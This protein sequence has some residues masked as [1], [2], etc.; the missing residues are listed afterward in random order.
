MPKTKVIKVTPSSPEPNR[1]REAAEVIRSGGLVAFP[2]ETVYGL[3][4]N[5]LL[6]RAVRR[7]FEVKRR[8][9]DN[10][11]I[12]HIARFED[13]SVLASEVP[14]AA[15]RL[16][17][18]FWPG[19]LTVI[20]PRS[21]IVPDAPTAGLPT[22]AI[23][24]P[25]HPVARALI[26]EADLPIAAPSANL[27]GRPSPT[28]AA[29]V[30]SDLDGCIDLLIDGGEIVYGLESTVIDL[31]SDP[32]VVLRPGPIT[33]ESLRGVLGDVNLHPGA[34]GHPSE[35]EAIARSP[36]MK[37]RHY[38]PRAQLVVVEGSP[39][40]I[41]FKIREL[42]REHKRRGLRVGAIVTAEHADIDYAADVLKIVGDRRNPRSIARNL[43]RVLREL[44]AE[45]VEWAVIEGVEPRGIGLAI[46]NRLKKAAGH[47][48]VRV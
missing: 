34:L 19:P 5:A 44:D 30:L 28:S 26:S 3:G 43:F 18:H 24:M 27:A 31:T 48:V 39:E 12:I 41:P 1:I 25:S 21:D 9:K 14:P 29:H 38:A 23:R 40:R 4:A 46:M 20:L 36:G 37:Y 17:R 2:T 35:D 15:E 22:V 7:I 8:P 11:I 33:L 32:P 13:L 47:R 42:V 45:G 16:A 6:D 10:P